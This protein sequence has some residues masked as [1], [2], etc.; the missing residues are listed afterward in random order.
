M[1]SLDPTQRC[2]LPHRALMHRVV[3]YA[4]H[5]KIDLLAYCVMLV[6]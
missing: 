2:S 4:L 1:P 6:R 3:V 5:I